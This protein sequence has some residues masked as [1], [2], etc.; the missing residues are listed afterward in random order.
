MV[1]FGDFVGGRFYWAEIG[2]T[3]WELQG[4]CSERVEPISAKS[5][6]STWRFS[7]PRMLAKDLA[8]VGTGCGR[9]RAS[10]ARTVGRW[11]SVEAA[12]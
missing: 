4:Y 9:D 12:P 10:M 7:R 6:R 5:M 1:I 8:L 2:S 11:G 3:R